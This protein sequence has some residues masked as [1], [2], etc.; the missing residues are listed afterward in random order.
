[1]DYFEAQRFIRMLKVFFQKK[2][3]YS[4]Q[5]ALI[6]FSCIYIC[7]SVPVGIFL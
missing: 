5:I 2:E 7:K 1:M 3:D 4:E 6:D